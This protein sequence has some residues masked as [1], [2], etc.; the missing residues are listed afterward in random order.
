MAEE[1]IQTWSS[2]NTDIFS[3]I[4]ITVQMC[5]SMCITQKKTVNECDRIFNRNW[6]PYSAQLCSYTYHNCILKIFLTLGNKFHFRFFFNFFFHFNPPKQMHQYAWYRLD[7]KSNREKKW[8]KNWKSKWKNLNITE[9][10]TVLY[11]K[12]NLPS[13]GKSEKPTAEIDFFLF[14]VMFC[15][16][17][18][19]YICWL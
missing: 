5:A 16:T 3:F 13:K 2:V 10:L 19:I 18:N 9:P 1:N 11:R 6:I 12:W 15:L 7:G 17:F 4:T 14:Q 8:K